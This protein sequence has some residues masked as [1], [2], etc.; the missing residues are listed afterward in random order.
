MAKREYETFEKLAD[1]V[2]HDSNGNEWKIILEKNEYY[3]K[4]IS[5]FVNGVKVE[6]STISKNPEA[7]ATWEKWK[8]ILKNK[9]GQENIYKK[10]WPPNA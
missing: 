1:M 5:F 8:S 2:F 10:E 9:P 4:R 6:G 3:L 7:V